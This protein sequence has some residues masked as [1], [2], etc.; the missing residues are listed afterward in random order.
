MRL[1]IHY[2]VI[3]ITLK[4]WQDSVTTRLKHIVY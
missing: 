2:L 3:A 4:Y 1:Y